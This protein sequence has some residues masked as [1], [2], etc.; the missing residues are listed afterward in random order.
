MAVKLESFV[1]M[2]SKYA[3]FRSRETHETECYLKHLVDLNL[4][5]ET[6]ESDLKG[7]WGYKTLAKFYG[8][9]TTTLTGTTATMTADLLKILSSNALEEKTGKDVQVVEDLKGTAGSFELTQI[10]STTNTTV[11]VYAISEQGISTKLK[12]VVASP[13]NATE[14]K[15]DGKTITTDSSV[16]AIRA[17]YFVAKDT[18]TIEGKDFVAKNYEFE[19]LLVA[20]NIEDGKIYYCNLKANNVTVSPTF[21]LTSVNSADAPDAVELSITLL[22]DETSGNSYELNFYEAE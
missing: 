2:G 11:V 16:T 10:P 12:K 21:S 3:I 8:D 18:V 1:F 4:S 14:F 13:S 20:K 9:R 5:D 19:A 6:A 7:G 17:F 22:T 15:V